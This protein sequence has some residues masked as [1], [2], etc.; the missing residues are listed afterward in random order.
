MIERRV[1]V[2]TIFV[3]D[4]HKSYT[5]L[6]TKLPDVCSLRHMVIHSK[7]IIN[8]FT[9]ILPTILNHCGSTQ[10][11]LSF[12]DKRELFETTNYYVPFF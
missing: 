12:S 8:V 3:T 1:N 5:N 6:T 10:R 9:V 11:I 7:K 2:G 4:G